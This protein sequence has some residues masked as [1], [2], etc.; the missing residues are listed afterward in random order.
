MQDQHCWESVYQKPVTFDLYKY[1]SD[2][3][4]P[5]GA[6][7]YIEKGNPNQ[8]TPQSIGP[9]IQLSWYFSD[10][11]KFLDHEKEAAKATGDAGI[12]KTEA[13]VVPSS[14]GQVLKDVAQP[15]V[16]LVPTQ[17]KHVMFDSQDVGGFGFDSATDGPRLL[18]TQ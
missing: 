16:D 6:D 18:N 15:L 2:Q 11:L 9:P 4:Y 3:R 1:K 14:D 8:E 10:S 17:P 7:F 5:G 12:A 13:Q